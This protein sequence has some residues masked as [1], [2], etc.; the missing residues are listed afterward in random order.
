MKEVE[1]ANYSDRQRKNPV[2]HKENEKSKFLM[3][4]NS[5]YEVLRIITFGRNK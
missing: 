5:D 2:K 1:R 4:T 3:E